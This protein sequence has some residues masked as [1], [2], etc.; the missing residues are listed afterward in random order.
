MKD[1]SLNQDIVFC[2]KAPSNPVDVNYS[3]AVL[4]WTGNYVGVCANL[5][6]Y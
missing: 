6:V 1:I 5:N 2:L 4:H 3:V